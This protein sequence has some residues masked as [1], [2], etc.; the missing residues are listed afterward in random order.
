MP[1]SRRKFLQTSIVASTAASLP[2][3]PLFGQTHHPLH[4][5]STSSRGETAGPE[6]TRGIGEYPGASTEFF[7]PGFAIDSTT[8]RNLALRRPA[9]H[10]SAY[11]YNLTAQLVTDGIKH[12]TLPRWVSCTTSALGTLPKPDRE[13]L[14]D[15][16]EANAIEFKGGYGTAE[17]HLGGGTEVPEID[18]LRVFV[19]TPDKVAADQVSITIN[20]SE[21]GANW[22]PVANLNGL[23][24]ID[25]SIL[26]P[27]DLVKKNR[28]FYPSFALKTPVRSRFYQVEVKL[29]GVALMDTSTVFRLGQVEFYRGDQREEMGGP[30]SFTSAWMSAGLGEEWVAV[31]LGAPCVFDRVK[32]SWIARAAEGSIQTSNDGVTWKALK[33]LPATTAQTDDLAIAPP[34]HAR[35]VRVHMTRPTSPEGYILSELEVFG[36]GGPVAKG[37]A[38]PLADSDGRLDLAGGGWKLERDSEVHAPGVALSAAGFNDGTWLPATVP[39]TILASYLNAGAIPDPNFGQNQ[40][41]VSDSFFYADFWYRRTFAAPVV[42]K[43]KL[44]WLQFDGI[45]W[46]AEVFLNGESLG[47]ILGGF[48]RAKFDVTDKLKPG[49]DNVLAVRVLKNDT[50]GSCKQ[51]TYESP[52]PN[53]GAPGA[54]NPTMHASI[55]WDWI[56]TIR[57]RNT[58]IWGDVFLSTTGAVSVEDP[59]VTSVVPDASRAEVTVSVNLV[60]HRAEEISGTLR[61]RLGQNHFEQKV[62]LAA[63]AKQ[64][65]AFAPIQLTNPE[66]WWPVGYGEAKLHDAEISFELGGGEV[67]DRKAFK[68]GIRQMTATDA[69]GN[70]RLFINGRRFIARG[71]NWGFA[72][73]MLRYRAREYDASIRYHREMNFTMIR[74]WVGQV[75]DMAF[76]EACDRHG[77]VV[78]QDF[79][80]ANPWDGPVPNDDAMFLANARDVVAKIRSHASVGLY[81]GRNEGFPP[82]ALEKGIRELLA[83]LHPGIHYIGSSADD[84]VSGHGPYRALPSN[85]YFKHA[86]K[87][88]HSEIGMPCI[89][90]IESVK[91]MMPEASV[92]PQGLDWGLHDFSQSGAQGAITFNASIANEY[93]GAHTAEEWISLAQFV[94]Y[95]G[96]RAIFEAGGKDRMGILLW[97]SHPCWPSFVWQT[98]DFYLEP[99]AAYFACRKASEPLHI[100]WNRLTG[101]IE[102]VNLSAGNQTGL[103]AKL[104]ILNLD[105]STKGGRTATLD[106]AEDSVNPLFKVEYPAGLTAV[107]FLRLTLSQGAKVV[108]T[109]LYYRGLEEGNYR[110]VRD[111]AKAKVV[112][113]TTMARQGDVWKL[114]TELHNTSATPALMVRLKAV[115]KVAGDRILPVIYEDNYFNLMPGESRTIRT[116]LNHAD[117]RGQSPQ[118]MVSGFN[119]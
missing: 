15:H 28:I 29:G 64:Q 84:V 46:K 54:D 3:L 14:L 82:P 107:H 41:Y 105:G 31:D 49:A 30:Y 77:V 55:G 74:N 23:T 9:T 68:A 60:N 53:G 63:S 35:Y 2:S 16:W 80:L 32:L 87:Q 88:F 91:L 12:T 100:Q 58:G 106:S 8:Y 52:G 71:G 65:V 79:W 119:L 99:T 110:A 24:P 48:M 38:T 5:T 89:P 86:D 95:E 92:W 22:T 50:P 18:R 27:P 36:R 83:E 59:L 104:E 102:V 81:C 43:G 117:T 62:K 113:G 21:D 108:S 45:N 78:W 47:H 118:M 93:G 97:M 72:E 96:Y 75:P 98:Y 33:A 101:F 109:N 11:D 10:S 67:S 44:Q 57:G 76:Y 4:A 70:L 115:R 114:T 66:L 20:T 42:A 39:G 61:G 17:L 7:G 34:A 94:N 103:S 116:E 19:V 111:L 37:A 85:T 1:T 69:D 90:S 40:L 56:P 25:G 112:S 73:S 51:K 13:T 6:F 26:Y